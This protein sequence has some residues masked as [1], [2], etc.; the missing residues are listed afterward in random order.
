MIIGVISDTHGR[1]TNRTLETLQG[2]ELIIHAGDV[3]NLRVLDA[4]EDIAPVYG[5][6]GNTD[7][8]RWA[9][10]LPMTRMVEAGGKFIYVIHDIAMLDIDPRAAGVDVIIYG[11]SHIPKKDQK[12]GVIYFN[13]GSAGPKR[14]KLPICLG[15]IRLQEDELKFQWVDLEVK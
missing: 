4:L 9:Q 1:I 14:F 3:G 10:T 11:H 13:P 5:V 8:E 15:R 2:S 12:D 6:R 7:R